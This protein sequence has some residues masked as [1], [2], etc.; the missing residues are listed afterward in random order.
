MR[1]H[2]QDDEILSIDLAEL[3]DSARRNLRLRAALLNE[4]QAA[5]ADCAKL[6]AARDDRHV[7][8]VGGEP[9]CEKAADGPGADDA[10]LHARALAASSSAPGIAPESVLILFM[11][12]LNV[13]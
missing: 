12:G 8:A 13:Q 4:A 7:L 6:R 1:L 9:S 10:D 11:A 3:F 2:P 5:G